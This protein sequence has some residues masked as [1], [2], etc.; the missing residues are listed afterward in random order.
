MKEDIHEVPHDRLLAEFEKA[1]TLLEHDIV[2]DAEV[3][4]MDPEKREW[5]LNCVHDCLV[6]MKGIVTIFP[7]LKQ[8]IYRSFISE[9]FLQLANGP[10]AVMDVVKDGILKRK[11][12]DSGILEVIAAGIE[13]EKHAQSKGGK[14]DS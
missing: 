2:K 9:M 10:N 14:L 11:L 8:S 3:L 7:T 13:K 6:I 5:V 1:I 12:K 4:K